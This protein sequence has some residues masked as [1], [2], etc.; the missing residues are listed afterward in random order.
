MASTLVRPRPLVRLALLLPLA[1]GA[2]HGPMAGAQDT[3]A[4]TVRREAAA[5][6]PRAGGP[7]EALARLELTGADARLG[8]FSSVLRIER[9]ERLLLATDR[10][11]LL[12]AAPVF[13]TDGGLADLVDARL[14]RF[15]LPRGWSDDV[16]SM[17]I[18][19][20][21]L[22]I[23]TEGRRQVADRLIWLDG[24]LRAPTGVADDLV[25]T[26]LGLAPNRGFEALA[27]LPGD[28]WLGVAETRIDGTFPALGHD[29]RRWR[30]R[31]A[32]DHAPTGAD[33]FGDRLF[34]VERALG[35][36][37]GWQARIACLEVAELAAGEVLEPRTLARL[38]VGD[39]IDN[40]EG[41][42]VWANGPDLEFLLVSDDNFHP[43]QRS[44]LL[45]YRWPGGASGGCGPGPHEE[46]ER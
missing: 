8:G 9:G 10:G 13:A 19:G 22:M 30:Y 35:V 23:G 34:F 11:W 16:E 36:I 46:P 31:A 27:S 21:R 15:P 38:G 43:A 17:A 37:G 5:A 2:C 28:G 24:P 18:V 41:I 42:A 45:H 26:G 32:A 33:R 7:L 4:L 1:L 20:G 39:R 29:G 40:M 25:V 3:V 12:D 44:L 6:D 14:H